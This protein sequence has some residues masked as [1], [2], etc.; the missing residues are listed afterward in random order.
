[1]RET[2]QLG[3]TG[4]GKVYRVT[5]QRCRLVGQINHVAVVE[6]SEGDKLTLVRFE[7][8]DGARS[9]RGKQRLENDNANSNKLP[10]HS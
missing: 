1:M 9:P 6:S 5:G 10:G 8:K 3:I 2:Q 4:D 7:R